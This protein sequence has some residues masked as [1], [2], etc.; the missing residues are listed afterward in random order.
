MLQGFPEYLGVS[1]QDYTPGPRADRR[2][3]GGSADV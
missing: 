2:Q 1:V 3:C